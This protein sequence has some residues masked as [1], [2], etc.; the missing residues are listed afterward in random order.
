MQLAD[1]TT[2]KRQVKGAVVQVCEG[3]FGSA[4]RGPGVVGVV[5]LKGAIDH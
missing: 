2:P 4:R 1:L 5:D 3:A